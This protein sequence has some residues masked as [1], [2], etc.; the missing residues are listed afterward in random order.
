MV[1]RELLSVFGIDFDDAGQKK[2]QNALDGLKGQAQG[3]GDTLGSLKSLLAG[4]A[5][6]G[7]FAHAAEAAN[8][9]A[10]HVLRT[11]ALFGEG[12]E[13]VQ[14]WAGRMAAEMGRGDDD[15]LGLANAMKPVADSMTDNEA[16]ASKMS[17]TM[18]EL[19]VNMG[20]FFGESDEETL[21]ALGTG[22]MGAD[23]ALRKYGIRLNDETL[24]EFARSKGITKSV[25]NMKESEKAHLR[26]LKIL[27]ST[28]KYQNAAQQ[29]TMRY[30]GAKRRLTERVNDLWQAMGTGLLP[31][32]AKVF[33]WA[34]VGIER[35]LKFM[36]GTDGL[37]NAMISL[38][39]VGAAI[40]LPV[41]WGLLVPLIP[42]LVVFGAFVLIMDEV[43]Q[44]F[45]GADTE[46][47]AF[48]DA[49]DTF[50]KYGTGNTGLDMLIWTVNR[51]RDALG[52]AMFS[53]Y[54]FFEGLAT[55]D[56]S[57]FKGGMDI[58]KEAVLG[59]HYA[60]VDLTNK[61]IGALWDGLKGVHYFLV[62]LVDKF[63]EMNKLLFAAIA[64]ATT[65]DFGPLRDAAADFAFKAAPFLGT[66]GA[67]ITRPFSNGGAPASINAGGTGLESVPVQV[68]DKVVTI[69]VQQEPGENRE[70]FAQRVAEITRK[71][72]SD[73]DEDL[74]NNLVQQP[75]PVTP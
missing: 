26:Y 7:V 52:F 15:L 75:A 3:V 29:A 16:E 57:A 42:L 12:A 63:L 6:V 46:I 24:Q 64:A 37:R 74:Y 39:I 65:G 56:W 36:E 53:T 67:A 8:T 40:L 51:V 32:F 5:I 11:N 71:Q 43:I 33:T 31:I 1:I 4:S 68:G 13:D 41:L 48:T 44:T 45:M 59:V 47:S 61:A 25:K 20:S 17:T 60:L 72:M 38:A 55:G 18:A 22:M 23:R 62:G 21:R 27:A 28:T 66:A 9:L 34:S 69:N 54:A 19:A 2:A 50:E 49:L 73:R 10:M 35:F 14:A 70:D 30:D 58:V